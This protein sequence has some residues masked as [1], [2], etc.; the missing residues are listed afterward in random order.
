VIDKLLEVEIYLL[1]HVLNSS[2]YEKTITNRF[3]Q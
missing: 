1:L 3:H 2:G